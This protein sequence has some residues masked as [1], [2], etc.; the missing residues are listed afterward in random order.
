MQAIGTLLAV[1]A[2]I[3]VP[4]VARERESQDRIADRYARTRNFLLIY[5]GEIF[6]T[7]AVRTMT[8]L[9]RA[10]GPRAAP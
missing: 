10:P 4:M 5:A 6:G 2:A 9:S 7:G 3:M 1:G 8:G